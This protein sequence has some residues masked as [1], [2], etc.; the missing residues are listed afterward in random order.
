MSNDFDRL[1]NQLQ[2]RIVGFGPFI[3]EWSSLQNQSTYPPY[4]LIQLN[5]NEVL[6]ELAVAGFKKDE[7][8]MEEHEGR[9]VI[10]GEKKSN[11]KEG[12]YQNRGIATRTFEKSLRLY[13]YFKVDTASIE[14]GILTVK[15]VREVPESAKPKLIAIK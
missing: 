15:F 6:L 12:V 7:I 13:N 9:V 5:E 11:E 14:D 3:T 1:F 10:R 2:Q 4:N 8:I